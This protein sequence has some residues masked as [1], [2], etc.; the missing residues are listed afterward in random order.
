MKTK[1]ILEEFDINA[2]LKIHPYYNKRY[3]NEYD[4]SKYSIQRHITF[5][6]KQNTY[7]IAFKKNDYKNVFI[8]Y[9]TQLFSN[10]K[11]VTTINYLFNSIPLYLIPISTNAIKF[12]K[13]V[14]N[15]WNL[16]HE[17]SPELS[18]YNSIKD[19]LYYMYD[20]FYV[21]TL[22]KYDFKYPLILFNPKNNK[23]YRFHY[24]VRFPI[25]NKLKSYAI[26][27]TFP[28]DN[29]RQI[30]LIQMPDHNLTY[31]FFQGVITY[32][33]G[34]GQVELYDIGDFKL[35]ERNNDDKYI[36]HCKGNVLNGTYT[37]LRP[38]KS[39]GWLFIKN[40]NQQKI[41]DVKYAIKQIPK[42]YVKYK[43]TLNMPPAKKK[44]HDFLY[45]IITDKLEKLYSGKTELFI[46][47]YFEYKNKIYTQL[48]FDFDSLKSI[49]DV[50]DFRKYIRKHDLLEYFYVLFTGNGFHV[51]SYCILENYT[52]DEFKN[53]D[54]YTKY[55]YLDSKSSIR[56]I[57]TR[58]PYTFN[59][60]NNITN[61]LIDYNN[62]SYNTFKYYQR[63]S[64]N[65]TPNMIYGFDFYKHALVER[66]LPKVIIN[67]G[68]NLYNKFKE[69]LK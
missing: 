52:H 1:M 43:Y 6:N 47:P 69:L 58:I 40:K 24:D 14:N 16:I 46:N 25:D 54:L 48:D 11:N 53:S 17:L 32:G 62:F 34:M 57:E 60:K 18:N 38:M 56:N 12:I 59:F 2:Y 22:L 26:P 20:K 36:I 35:I 3:D 50:I 55:T 13:P 65:K 49:D 5:R 45:D 10:N 61:M 19:M 37:L 7:F 68:S 31:Q 15:I 51:K 8:L 33:Y 44:S 67:K 4:L 30:G 29:K 63:K 28:N 9:E 23:E 66:L 21:N 27:R 42:Y 64:L 41:N 39:M